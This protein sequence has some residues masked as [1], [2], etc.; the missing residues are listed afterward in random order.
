MMR[1]RRLRGEA[2]AAAETVV[3]FP[4]FILLL[5]M[6]VQ[7]ALWLNASHVALAAAQEGARVAR[8]AATDGAAQEQ[9]GEA[10]AASFLAALAPHTINGPPTVKGFRTNDTAGIE[11]IAQGTS[12]IPGFPSF[13][14]DK[15]SE[16]PVER[17]RSRTDP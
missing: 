12:I 6:V 8:M 4:A 11:V 3:I 1:S 2:G 7:F 10:K 16:G 14:I 9:Q 15:T 13:S 17:F 5:L